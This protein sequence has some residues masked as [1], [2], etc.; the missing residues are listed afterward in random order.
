MGCCSLTAD[1]YI[2]YQ[3]DHAVDVWQLFPVCR[4]CIEKFVLGFAF[5][6]GKNYKLYSKSVTRF[7]Y[8]IGRGEFSTVYFFI[9]Q[10]APKGFFP[11][12]H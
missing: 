1:I 2:E 9:L 7:S 10:L 5:S 6:A 4:I 12:N 11:G 8:H 3:F